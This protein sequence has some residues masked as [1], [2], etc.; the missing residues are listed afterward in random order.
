MTYSH[1]VHGRYHNYYLMLP[2]N[3]CSDYNGESGER[4]EMRDWNCLLRVP[5]L[6]YTHYDPHVLLFQI[7][8]VYIRVGQN[9][10]CVRFLFYEFRIILRS[11]LTILIEKIYKKKLYRPSCLRAVDSNCC[12]VFMHIPVYVTSSFTIFQAIRIIKTWTS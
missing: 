3:Y 5:L 10:V 9:T 1:Y 11:S 12:T 6:M 4:D 2:Y 8:Q 7:T